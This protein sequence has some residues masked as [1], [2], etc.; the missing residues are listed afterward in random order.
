VY[1]DIL[2][3]PW[4]TLSL[5][6]ADVEIIS[7]SETHNNLNKFG[8][9]FP[10]VVGGNDKNKVTETRLPHIKFDTMPSAA[11][12]KRKRDEDMENNLKEMVQSEI[13]SMTF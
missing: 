7:V 4:K 8:K 6:T 2:I 13:E 3:A 9:I 1:C 10:T 11:R 12:I 5:S